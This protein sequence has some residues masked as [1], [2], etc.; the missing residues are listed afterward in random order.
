MEQS[1]KSNSNVLI[2]AK[3]NK[4]IPHTG[5]K[6]SL[7]QCEQQHRCQEDF[8]HLKKKLPLPAG[9]AAAVTKFKS[10]YFSHKI[11]VTKLQLQNLSK[12]NLVIFFSHN[13]LIKK[14]LS[15]NYSHKVFVTTFL[16]QNFS[17][18]ILVTQ[19][20]I[21]LDGENSLTYFYQENFL[22]FLWEKFHFY[23][24]LR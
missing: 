13:I 12:K 23:H 11:L 6:E 3:N 15:Q 16:S 9:V 10:P 19:F 14:K 2:V 8:K 1:I 24:F 4:E 21:S 17:H 5:D 7:N 18:K 20:R 22:F